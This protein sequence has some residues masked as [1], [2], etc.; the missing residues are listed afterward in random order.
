MIDIII[1]DITYKCPT[2]WADINIEKYKRICKVDKELPELDMDQE[3][4]H[5]LTGIDL[6]T[7]DI[8]PMIEFNKLRIIKDFIK[9][10]KN[11][12]LR[13]EVNIDGVRYKMANDITKTSTR[14]YTDLDNIL[15]GTDYI[16]KLDLAMAIMFRPVDSSNEPEPYRVISVYE[17]AEL[18]NEKFP[19]DLMISVVG[20]SMVLGQISLDHILDSLEKKKSLT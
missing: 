4:I 6:E 3:I 8:M 15:K 18:F 2:N 17:R 20:F 16:D 9:D 1:D 19:A 12:K 14:E 11:Q 13:W 7:L 5:I 10:T